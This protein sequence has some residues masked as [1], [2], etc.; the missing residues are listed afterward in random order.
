M[1][2]GS[3]IRHRPNPDRIEP[4]SLSDGRDLVIRPIHAADGP[5]IAAGFLLLNEDEVR[6]RFLHL[7]KALSEDHLNLLTHPVPGLQFVVVAAE[8]LPPGEALVAAVA[9][10]A[11]DNDDPSRAEFGLLVSHFVSGLGLGGRLLTRMIEWAEQNGI[12]ELWGDVLDNNRP[13]LELVAKMGFHRES[14]RDSPGLIRIRRQLP[15]G[16]LRG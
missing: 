8:P 16:K 15:A 6:K 14:L 9:R 1:K 13:M 11:R 12:V 7:L 2:P 5:P 10:V 3:R 4:V